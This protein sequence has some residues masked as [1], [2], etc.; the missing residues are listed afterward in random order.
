MS[1]AP[2]ALEVRDLRYRYP[3]GT[4]ALRGIDF[5]VQ[6]GESV[7]L[8][9][10]GKVVGTYR[11]MSPEQARGRPVDARSDLYSLG[12]ILFELICGRAPFL[13]ERPHDL[14]HDI[15]ERPPPAVA[16]LNPGVDPRLALVAERLLQKDPAER[17]QRA[18]DVRAYFL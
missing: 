17:F 16:S 7:G 18:D 14:W 13:A 9:L 4:E 15:M 12:V 3:D 11:Y 8:T 5:R 10:H 6:P 1:P 2:P